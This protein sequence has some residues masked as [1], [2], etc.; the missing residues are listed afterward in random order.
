EAG[1]QIALNTWHTLRLDISGKKLRALVDG[2]E[3]LTVDDLRLGGKSG[4]IGLWVDDGTT[5]YFSNLR[6][7]PA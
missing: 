6:I 1:A 7:R 2:I 4:G 3:I 5:G